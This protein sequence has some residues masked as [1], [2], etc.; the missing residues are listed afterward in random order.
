VKT[1]VGLFL[2]PEKKIFCS[3]PA[4][5]KPVLG[6]YS[7]YSL[8]IATIVAANQWPVGLMDQ[9]VQ[10]A[11]DELE[12]CMGSVDTPWGA[13]RAEYGHPEPFQIDHVELGNEDWFSTDYPARVA[14]LYT[15]LK[16]KYPGITY[17]FSAYDENA[18]YTI[19]IPD[20]NMWDS[21]HYEG[22]SDA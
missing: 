12:F 7:G 21:H 17:I 13:K 8:D 15:S 2:F 4:E 14:P 1:W 19:R 11:L 22:E 3:H 16:A 10:E 6:V 9:V 18:G 5:I 20:G